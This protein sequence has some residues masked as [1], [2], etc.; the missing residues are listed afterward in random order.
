MLDVLLGGDV[1]D[2]GDDFAGDVLAVGFG[3]S[4]E[5]L[6]CAAD[7]VDFGSVDGEGLYAHEANAG[8]CIVL[9]MS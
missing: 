1:A 4:L 6:F 9:V 7:D 3:Y 8:A 5:L 2:K